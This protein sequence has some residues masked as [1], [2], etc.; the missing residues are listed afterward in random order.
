MLTDS[1]FSNKSLPWEQ[2]WSHRD[3]HHTWRE[4]CPK[5]GNLLNPWSH[6]STPEAWDA[7]AKEDGYLEMIPE[8]SHIQ[9]WGT[10]RIPWQSTWTSRSR[11]K[12]HGHPTRQHLS[13]THLVASPWIKPVPIVGIALGWV[14]QTN[15]ITLSQLQFLTTMVLSTAVKWTTSVS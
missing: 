5:N 2:I 10:P 14:Q 3:L 13:T 8:E 11:R 12:V 1:K 6:P 4:A 9:A 7:Q 15:C